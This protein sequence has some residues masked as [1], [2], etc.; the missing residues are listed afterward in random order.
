L[1]GSSGHVQIHGLQ[2]SGDEITI[3]Q[4]V[5]FNK[6]TGYHPFFLWGSSNHRVEFGV[7]ANNSLCMSNSNGVQV[8]NNC[9]PLVWTNI[10]EGKWYNIIFAADQ[11][12]T[13]IYVNGIPTVNRQL[14][15]KSIG[16][17]DISG[18]IIIGKRGL[19]HLN[20]T[21][22]EIAIWNR[23]LNPAEIESVYRYD[24]SQVQTSPINGAVIGDSRY[25]YYI[26]LFVILVIVIALAL[27]L[28]NKNKKVRKRVIAKKKS[29]I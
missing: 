20:G 16:T 29:K 21:V 12:S 14:Q 26:I 4:W 22:D 28:R 17:Y 13:M 8:F 25:K 24:G 18:D 11:D 7:I 9:V 15:A 1:D 5:K 23:K 19:D 3:S 2:S 6:I 10:S 27:F